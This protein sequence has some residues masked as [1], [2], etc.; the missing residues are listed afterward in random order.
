MHASGRMES[1]GVVCV[2]GEG[3]IIDKLYERV[4]R[5]PLLST[6]IIFQFLIR[7]TKKNVKNR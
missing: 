4:K 1:G 6:D 3:G 2:R 7:F 5:V